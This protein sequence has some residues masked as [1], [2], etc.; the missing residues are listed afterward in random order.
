MK[1]F[2][3]PTVA[4]RKYIQCIACIH[5]QIHTPYNGTNADFE[6]KY[7]F[8]HVKLRDIFYKFTV[9]HLHLDFITMGLS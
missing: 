8:I 2:W 6:K 7:S 4:R 3:S 9:I 5:I 1:P